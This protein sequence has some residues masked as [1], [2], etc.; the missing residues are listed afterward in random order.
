MVAGSTL[1]GTVERVVFRNPETLYT[2]LR[3]RTT[4]REEATVVGPPPE[5]TGG[6][7]IRVDGEWVRDRRFGE[8]FR[9]RTCEILPPSSADGIRRYLGSGLVQGIGPVLARRLVAKFGPDTLRVISEDPKRLREVEGIGEKRAREIE[10]A[11]ASQRSVAEILSFLQGHGV[12]AAQALR[13]HRRYGDEAVRILK[14]NPYRLA[15]EV[16]GVGFKTA[17]ALAARL[18]LATDSPE[19]A[20]AGV[21]H[22]LREG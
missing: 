9:A 19:R 1:Q 17:D 7:S 12:G 3:V 11:L 13:I 15:T 20:V 6:E 4:G 22:V 8:Q 18:G 5:V 2:V 21:L 16:H 14:E 10:R